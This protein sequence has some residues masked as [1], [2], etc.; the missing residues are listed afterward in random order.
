MADRGIGQRPRA[1][2]CIDI[3]CRDAIFGFDGGFGAAV[4]GGGEGFDIFAT[5]SQTRCHR[6]AAVAD[7]VLAA[8]LQCGSE[9][10]PGDASA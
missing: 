10:E 9:V 3:E 6:V 2:F 7:E 4:E 5:Q 1:G 8:R